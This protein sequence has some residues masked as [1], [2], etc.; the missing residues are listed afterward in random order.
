MGVRPASVR[1]SV[2]P[3]VRLS[4][5]PSV[6]NPTTFRHQKSYRVHIGAVDTL[7]DPKLG[8]PKLGHSDLLYGFYGSKFSFYMLSNGEMIGVL[9]ID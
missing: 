4:V 5:C 9:S 7:G 6:N 2:R 8:D 3:S 1:P